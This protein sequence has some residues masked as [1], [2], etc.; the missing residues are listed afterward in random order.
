MFQSG[1]SQSKADAAMI[2]V[3]FWP[4]ADIILSAMKDIGNGEAVNMACPAIILDGA[5]NIRVVGLAVAPIAA[6][7]PLS[8]VE[9]P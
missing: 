2:D 4:K 8:S 5:P 6:S 7:S 3:R 1:T 9:Q